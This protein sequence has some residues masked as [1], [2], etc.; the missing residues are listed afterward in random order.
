VDATKSRSVSTREILESRGDLGSVLF[1]IVER[2]ARVEE[3]LERLSRREES[4]RSAMRPAFLSA[5]D[6]AVFLGV[7][8][9]TLDYL[10]KARKIRCVQVGSQRGFIYAIDDLNEFASGRTIDTAENSLR[11]LQARKRDRR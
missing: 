7:D 10:R 3:R 1:E 5:A 2:L 9:S 6:A 4:P 8:R 11:R